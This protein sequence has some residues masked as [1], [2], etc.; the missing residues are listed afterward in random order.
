MSSMKRVTTELSLFTRLMHNPVLRFATA[1]TLGL[2]VSVMLLLFMR[3]MILGDKES[4][5][6][7]YRLFT[8]ETIF[9]PAERGPRERPPRPE[10]LEQPESTPVFSDEEIR[11][12]ALEFLTEQQLVEPETPALPNM[13]EMRRAREEMSSMLEE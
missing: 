8:L 12:E 6:V 4:D 10:F 1:I 11:Q 7:L 3:Y 9:L 5:G 13:E 2:M